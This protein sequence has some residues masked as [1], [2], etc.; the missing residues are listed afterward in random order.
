MEETE[1][2]ERHQQIFLFLSLFGLAFLLRV[3]VGM[4]Y[5]NTYDTYWYRGWAVALPQNGLFSI[6]S[7]AD[8]ISLDYPPLYLIPLYLVGLVYDGITTSANVYTQMLV[9]KFFPILF[10]ML[11]GI[12][13][14]RVCTKDFGE[15]V[16]LIGAVAWLLNPSMFF[17]STLWGQTDSVMA[18]FLL[19]SFWYLSKG[20]TNLACLLFAVAG[21]TK[22]QSLLFTPVFL[23]EFYYVVKFDLKRFLTGLGTAVATIIV[24]FLPFMIGSGDPLLFFHVYLS[25][26]DTYTYCSLYAFNLY[27]MMGLDWSTGLHD[28]NA[29]IGGMTY[30][31]FG[32]MMLAVALIALIVMYVRGRQRSAWVGGLFFM[33]CV[34]ML[35]TRMHER[36]QVIVL[37]FALMAYLVTRQLRFGISFLLL[38]IMTGLNQF[39]VLLFHVYGNQITP[40]ED[41][42][43]TVIIVMSAMN[44]LL[45]LAVSYFCAAYFLAPREKHKTGGEL[46]EASPQEPQISMERE[47]E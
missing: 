25:G 15:K 33:N 7:V 46:S 6:Y 17:N 47:V 34:F 44:V 31:M 40:W 11:C 41:H 32:Y 21:M 35:T 29:I 16:G 43:S 14:Y 20:R 39:M 36:Y 8:S 28:T 45:F 1:K 23:L 26:A 30:Q 42:F 22:Y 12:F 3:M 37:P 13:I 4:A 10:D 19:I 24:V 18:F 38:T 9:L 27:G 2:Q 5:I